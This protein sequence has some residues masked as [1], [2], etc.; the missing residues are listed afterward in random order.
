MRLFYSDLFLKNA[1][2]LPVAEQK[3]LAKLLELLAQEVFH[4]LLHTKKLKAEL[5]GSY[6]FRITRDWRVIFRRSDPIVIL[7]DVLH[8]KDAY[9]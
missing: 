9:R 4:P 2:L 6:S 7:I 8:R 1:K 5:L 3:K